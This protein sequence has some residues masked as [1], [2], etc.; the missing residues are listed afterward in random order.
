MSNLKIMIKAVT[1][2]WDWR[3]RGRIRKDEVK[4]DNSK[5]GNLRKTPEG[6]SGLNESSLLAR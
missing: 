3:T 1:I 5:T 6:Q 4:R 2:V